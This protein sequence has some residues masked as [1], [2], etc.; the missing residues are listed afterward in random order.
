EGNSYAW[1]CATGNGQVALSLANHFEE[2]FA[3]DISSHQLALA[4]K[5]ENITYACS[6]AENAHFPDNHFDLITVAQAL[7]W[8]DREHFFQ[9]VHRVSKPSGVLAI[10]GYGLPKINYKVDALLSEFC[11]QVLAEYW[12]FDR[13]TKPYQFSDK[14]G[15][16]KEIPGQSKFVMEQMMSRSELTGYLYTWSAVKEYLRHNQDDPVQD[17]MERIGSIWGENQK[18]PTRFSIFLKLLKITK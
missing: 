1:D 10:W 2:V 18:V 15:H 17:L 8:F 12:D 6:R 11:N 14:N 13:S 4:P 7:H 5:R 3:T 16:F 9:E